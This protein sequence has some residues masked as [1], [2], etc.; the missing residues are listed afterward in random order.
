[1]DRRIDT[2][3]RQAAREDGLRAAL[4]R[5]DIGSRTVGK[6]AI[7]NSMA[8]QAANH[9]M[10]FR[11]GSIAIPYLVDLL[12]QLQDR[13]R[14]SL[15]DRVSKWFPDL[16][17][18][19]E[20]TLRMLA[21]STSGY[22][23]WI[24]GNPVFIDA[25]LDNPFRQW[26]TQELVDAAFAR[27]DACAPGKCF[28]YAHTNFVIIERVIG[29]VTGQPVG[30]LMR[31]RV[32]R[33]L[34]VRQT[35]ISAFPE[36]PAPTLHAYGSDRGP[37]EDSTSW[38]PSW[39]IG[40]STIMTATIGDMIKAAKAFG[41]GALISKKASRE[42]FAPI[43]AGLGPFNEDFYY[44]LGILVSNG[45]AF[46]NPELNGYTAIAGYL[47]SRRISLAL[48]VTNGRRAAATGTNYSQKLFTIISEYLTPNHRVG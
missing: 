48:T 31:K 29:K 39:T 12:L 24:Q 32:L 34:G 37:Y 14:L 17:N 44:G 43:T 46:Q 42:R 18:A 1:M 4:V 2:L 22:P 8:G 10:H 38:S 45:W 41:T 16:P 28:S 5:V 11:I 40:K 13:D 7:G 33:P 36:I 35:K 26:K 3:V 21:S 9:R 15:D 20:V 19:D 25:F 47:P 30:R 6:S 23:D 27:E